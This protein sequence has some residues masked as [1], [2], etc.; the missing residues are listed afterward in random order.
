MAPIASCC[1]TAAFCSCRS[2]FMLLDSDIDP[3]DRSCGPSRRVLLESDMDPRC[4]AFC[5]LCS[6]SFLRSSAVLAL[7]TL[8]T[9]STPRGFFAAMSAQRVTHLWSCRISSSASS[10]L[11][12][13]PTSVAV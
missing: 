6:F 11:F 3:R 2:R 5:S 9:V 7:M 1:F 12:S 10:R 13:L 4:N 8:P